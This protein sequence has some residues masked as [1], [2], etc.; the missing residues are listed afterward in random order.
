MTRFSFNQ[1]VLHCAVLLCL[2]VCLSVCL[3]LT[4]CH[5]CYS[6]FFPDL[7]DALH[8]AAPN[9]CLWGAGVFRLFSPR[10]C[11][12][13]VDWLTTPLRCPPSVHREV[14][15]SDAIGG[16]VIPAYRQEAWPSPTE[17]PDVHWLQHDGQPDHGGDEPED[18]LQC[19]L[20]VGHLLHH[21]R[22]GQSGRCHGA[23]LCSKL[24]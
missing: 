6:E 17:G 5:T 4:V 2:S 7:C 15:R 20:E 22:D 23:P 21:L 24:Q 16:H 12:R 8:R 19:G 9:T 10:P 14:A 13:E 11:V 3:S 1:K 18:C